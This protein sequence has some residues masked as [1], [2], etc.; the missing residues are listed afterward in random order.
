MLLPR[1]DITRHQPLRPADTIQIVKDFLYQCFQKDPNLRVSAKKLLRH[2]WMQ[3]AR[4][5]QGDSPG[6]TTP[7][8]PKGGMGTHKGGSG[9]VRGGSITKMPLPRDREVSSPRKDSTVVLS[10]QQISQAEA[11]QRVQEWNEALNGES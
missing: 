9:S 4:R 11:I 2:A 8:K 7:A 3:T 1:R 10:K 6:Q 5:N